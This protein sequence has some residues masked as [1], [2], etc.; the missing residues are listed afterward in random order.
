M[1]ELVKLVAAKTGMPESVAK[2]AVDTVISHLKTKLP[3]GMGDQVVALLDGGKGLA[4]GTGG[5]AEVLK[6]SLGGLLNKFK[7]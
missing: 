1:N 5:S 3:D 4:S 6:G 7:K 2:I